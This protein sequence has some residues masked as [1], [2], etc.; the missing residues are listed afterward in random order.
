MEYEDTPHFKGETLIEQA[1]AVDTAICEALQKANSSAY[2]TITN[3]M[4]AAVDRM[5]GMLNDTKATPGALQCSIC[6]RLLKEKKKEC[7]CGASAAALRPVWKDD[8][9]RWF[10]NC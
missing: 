1:W 4:N 3:G 8:N 6:Q 7:H 10:G 9:G 2:A 5:Q